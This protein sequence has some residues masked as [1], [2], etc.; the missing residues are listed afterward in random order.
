MSIN[1]RQSGNIL[2]DKL[3]HYSTM[4]SFG[5]CRDSSKVA[6]TMRCSF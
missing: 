1:G 6:A 3:G 2:M 5:R 4:D